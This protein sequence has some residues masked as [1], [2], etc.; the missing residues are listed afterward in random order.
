MF[1]PRFMPSVPVEPWTGLVSGCQRSR[2]KRRRGRGR[3]VGIAV[4]ARVAWKLERHLLISGGNSIETLPCL[5]PVGLVSWISFSRIVTQRR[6]RGVN[7]NNLRYIE[8]TVV[9][10]GNFLLPLETGTVK[11]ALVNARSLAN[12]TFVLNNFYTQHDLDF[13]FISET[14]LNVG[15]MY[16]LIELSPDD[17]SFFS[18]PR[19]SGRS[20][21]LACVFKRIF[22]CRH[23]S[24]VNYQS[25]EAQVMMCDAWEA[26]MCVLVYCI[27]HQD[28]IRI[29][30]SSFQSFYPILCQ[31]VIIF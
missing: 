20:G 4:K 25:F 14:W 27:D 17:C 5:H 16:P 28:T 13:L 22:K 11:M 10:D 6:S 26:V 2:S 23:L 19:A 12:K 24:T 7:G 9:S 29:L 3:R 18:T 8:S 15:E 1:H 30:F 31:A 21:G